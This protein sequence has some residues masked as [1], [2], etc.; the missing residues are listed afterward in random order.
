MSII[1]HM[2]V[3]GFYIESNKHDGNGGTPPKRLRAGKFQKSVHL[4]AVLYK[5][6]FVVVVV[7]D[8]RATKA[9]SCCCC[10]CYCYFYCYLFYYICFSVSFSL[11]Q[12]NFIYCY[13]LC[14]VYIQKFINY[15]K[16]FPVFA[17]FNYNN[18]IFYLFAVFVVYRND[19]VSFKL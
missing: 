9:V 18:M 8:Q 19:L 2:T 7:A 5:K 16:Q 14:Q 15:A 3:F 1:K 6:L 10:C 4:I 11:I 13:T 17:F 12:F